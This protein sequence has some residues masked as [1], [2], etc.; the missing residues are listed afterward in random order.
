[1]FDDLFHLVASLDH[2]YKEGA[3]SC[4]CCRCAIALRLARVQALVRE[5]EFALGDPAEEKQPK[6]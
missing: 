4:A 2:D 1:M 3:H 6:P 5:M